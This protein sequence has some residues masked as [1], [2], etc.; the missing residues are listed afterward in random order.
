MASH[1][2]LKQQVIATALR[3]IDESEH[4]QIEGADVAQALGIDPSD[5]ALYS[6]FREAC[7]QGYLRCDFP[8]GMEIPGM[9]RR[10]S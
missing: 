2:D 7:D 10:P 3:L 6:A 8:G 4:G 1:G 5:S 9:V